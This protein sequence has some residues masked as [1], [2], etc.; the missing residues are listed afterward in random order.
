MDQSGGAENFTHLEQRLLV[1]EQHIKTNE[2]GL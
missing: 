2:G 1:Y